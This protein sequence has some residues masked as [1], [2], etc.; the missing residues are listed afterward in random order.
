MLPSYALRA[1]STSALNS[2][3]QSLNPELAL[4]LVDVVDGQRLGRSSS[5]AKKADADRRIAFARRS[6]LTSRSSC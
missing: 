6:S 5:P 2:A 1:I 4:V 3:T